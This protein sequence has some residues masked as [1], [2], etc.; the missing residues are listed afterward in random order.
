[1]LKKIIVERVLIDPFYLSKI[2]SFGTQKGKVIRELLEV[3]FGNKQYEQVENKVMHK[4]SGN[5]WS[6]VQ[7]F[8]PII[9]DY[10]K[11]SVN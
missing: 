11:K 9:R 1:M 4:D 10:A 5:S 3:K 6:I 2:R 7:F 8:L